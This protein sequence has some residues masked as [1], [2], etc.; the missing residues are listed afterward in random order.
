MNLD[1]RSLA[2]SRICLGFL[3]FFHSL[4]F[5][6]DWEE[7]YGPQGIS[8]CLA[9]S[10]PGSQNLFSTD[11]A[12]FAIF[13]ALP[14]GGICLALGLFTPV[15][16]AVCLAAS[17][18]L[19]GQT[20]YILNHGDDILRA[21]L[22][23]FIF[24]RVGQR[25]SLDAVRRR[26]AVFFPLT[27]HLAAWAYTFQVCLLYWMA[28]FFKMNSAWL[29]DGNALA[30][31]LNLEHYAT[32]LD[33]HFLHYPGIL[34]HLSFITPVFEFLGPFL[35]LSPFRPALCRMLAVCAFLFFHLVAIQ[36]MLAIGIFVP[37]CAILWLPFIP[38][39]VWDFLKGR[40]PFFAVAFNA[41]TKPPGQRRNR[42]DY[43]SSVLVIV[44]FL[45]ILAWNLASI[46]KISN[47]LERRDP[48]SPLLGL[49]QGWTMFSTPY[50][51]HGWLLLPV[52][53]A[54]GSQID[55][56]TGQPVTDLKPPHLQTYLGDMLEKRFLTNLFNLQDSDLLAAYAKSMALRWNQRHAPSQ[57]V[58]KLQI[59]FMSRRTQP[60]LTVTAP[61]P[62]TLYQT[63]F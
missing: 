29:L 11:A 48:L 61:V 42:W 3:V 33:I 20:P 32:P 31:S 1:S 41:D 22:L 35:L 12:E 44:L 34:R 40:H 60:D 9:A 21:L 16:C 7:F 45:D 2:L 17:L 30:Y 49:D 28:A 57:A 25:W 18:V 8:A 39:Y 10:H 62:Q 53:L 13:F 54:D 26:A 43:A 46:H 47:R 4:T 24:L 27:R 23:W 59:V 6:G 36:S 50:S 15:S 37:V 14:I 19:H 55:L 52:T 63:E 58:H 5:L 56:Y 38:G 51:A